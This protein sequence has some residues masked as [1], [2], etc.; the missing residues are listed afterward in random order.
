MEQKNYD[1]SGLSHKIV[2]VWKNGKCFPDAK[3]AELKSES[4]P[5]WLNDEEAATPGGVTNFFGTA[6][7]GTG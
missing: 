5:K 7:E 2:Q 1:L 4:H 6:Q 3:S